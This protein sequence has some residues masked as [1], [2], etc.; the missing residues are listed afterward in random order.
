MLIYGRSS[1]THLYWAMPLFFFAVA[2][3]LPCHIALRR[4]TKQVWPYLC[5]GG[6]FG[7]LIA[8]L[9]TGSLILYSEALILLCGSYGATVFYFFWSRDNRHHKGT[10]QMI[11]AHTKA[12]TEETP[13]DPLNRTAYPSLRLHLAR[14]AHR[15]L[16]AGLNGGR[17]TQC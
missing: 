16:R 6:S 11:E 4:F 5:L 17:L 14:F 13:N 2:I 8:A 12:E 1:V 3:A 7:S 9:A 15:K 10:E